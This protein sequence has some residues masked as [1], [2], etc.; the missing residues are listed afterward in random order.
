MSNA[1]SGSA[2][3]SIHPASSL[4]MRSKYFWPAFNSPSKVFSTVFAC[5]FDTLFVCCCRDRAEYKGK[6]MPDR[7]KVAF[8]FNKKKKKKG[9]EEAGGGDEVAAP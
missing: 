2:A 6:Y 9:D 8:G 4:S 1:A 3:D 5:S 7:L